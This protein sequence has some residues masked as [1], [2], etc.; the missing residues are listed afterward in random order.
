MNVP[1]PPTSE[2]PPD[3]ADRLRE[4]AARYGYPD[5]PAIFRAFGLV[6]ELGP[7][8]LAVSGVH[9][10]RF[11]FGERAREA[12]VLVTAHALDSQYELSIHRD[13]ALRAGL[14]ADEV[15]ALLGPAPLTLASLEPLE[16]ACVEVAVDVGAGRAPSPDAVALLGERG[17]VAVAALISHYRGL[18]AFAGILD[19]SPED[20]HAGPG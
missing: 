12:V 15:G 1:I 18:A 3:Y 13:E 4:H 8:M 19:L 7:A 16:R 14:A 11:P 2:L 6:D 9:R 20:F 5:V 17:F 10:R